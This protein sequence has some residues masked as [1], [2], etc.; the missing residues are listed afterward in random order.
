MKRLLA[1]LAAVILCASFLV[2]PASA[3]EVVVQGFVG[4]RDFTSAGQSG[5][6]KVS[7]F[8][9]IPYYGTDSLFTRRSGN[10][11]TIVNL[12]TAASSKYSG[13]VGI[14]ASFYVTSPYQMT[15]TNS[16]WFHLYAQDEL[17]RESQVGVADITWSS[18]IPVHNAPYTSALYRVSAKATAD[19]G[20]PITALSLRSA[21][22]W[23][24]WVSESLSNSD[25]MSVYFP[26]VR[27]VGTATSAELGA[28]E[29]MASEIA[30]QNEILNAMYGDI[31]EICNSI[32][33][34]TGDLLEAQNLTNQ[35]FSQ[36]I[37]VLNSMNTTTSN[38]YSLLQ[39]QFSL[40]LAA[41]ERESGNLQ[42]VII[43]ESGNV[44]TVLR[45]ES[46]AI[47]AAIDQAVVDLIEYLDSVFQGAVGELPSQNETT[48]GM[49]QDYGSAEGEIGISAGDSF[50]SVIPESPE[51]DNQLIAAFSLFNS[52]FTTLWY[53]LGDFRFF[54]IF[55]LT[56]ALVLLAIGRISKFAG[57]GSSKGGPE[58]KPDKGGSD[59]A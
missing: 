53:G 32:Y 58:K 26:S 56:L 33:S 47:Q 23:G 29:D 10:G 38:I 19:E 54:Y 1:C 57:A 16:P 35:Y 46:E 30:E 9:D 8:F 39:T 36:I 18:M 49:I 21:G 45:T 25:Y 24:F 5:D 40:L 2:V 48:G 42:D 51:F 22:D 13:T 59:G 14:Y 50:N 41:I 3:E 15:L 11:V 4:Y 37:P 55:P 44:Q 7:S 17:E 27:V 31:I 28:L 20:F 34:V 6:T 43:D 52:I 12:D